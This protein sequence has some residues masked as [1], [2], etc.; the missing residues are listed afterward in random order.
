[1]TSNWMHSTSKIRYA[2]YSCVVTHINKL[3]MNPNGHKL[4]G[5]PARPDASKSRGIQHERPT[6]STDVRF[7][8]CR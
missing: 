8:R 5:E 4:T 1:M 6:T 7:Y 3:C 2:V